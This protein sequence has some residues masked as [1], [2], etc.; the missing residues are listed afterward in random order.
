MYPVVMDDSPVGDY[1]SDRFDHV[2]ARWRTKPPAPE[3][4]VDA[5]AYRCPDCNVNVF[6]E[7]DVDTDG[8]YH[9]KVAHDQTCPWLARHEA[10]SG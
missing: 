2:E 5:L 9:I 3:Q 7:E 4:V 8:V 6:I 10:A 1:G